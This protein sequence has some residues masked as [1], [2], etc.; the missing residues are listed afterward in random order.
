MSRV[1]GD[2]SY[3]MPMLVFIDES[4]DPG[5]KLDRG[6]SP[7]FVIAMIIFATEEDAATTQKAIADSD[8]RRRHAGE[9]RFNKC[10]MR[11]EIGFSRR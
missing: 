2:S 8:A 5:F 3:A 11:S 4:G 1:H 9:F 6:A 10:S 7:I